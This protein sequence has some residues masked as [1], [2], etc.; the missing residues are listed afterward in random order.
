MAHEP[1]HGSCSCGRNEYSIQIPENVTERAEVYFDSSR[2]NRRFHGTPITAWLRVPLDWYQSSTHAF[3]PDET[4]SSIR[5]VFTPR[6]APET[7]RIFCGFCGTPLTFWT[8]EPRDE[9]DFM[10]VVIGS[11]VSEDQ[12]VLE[13]LGLLP[14]DFD[15]EESEAAPSS[16]ALAPARDT[17]SSVI[18]PSFGN[19]PGISRSFRRGTAGGIPWFEEMVEGS[20]LGRLMRARRGMGVS[21]DQST[22]FEWEISEWHDDGTV[23]IAQDDSDSNSHSTGKRKRVQQVEAKSKQK[24][25]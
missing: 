23:G 19:L 17:S 6:H 20:R 14:E 18:V 9:A 22:S 13:E 15:E 1:L 2:D 3:F 8:E 5:R 25:A 4:H 11:L 24:R 10:N 16:S 7:R 12:R 21:D